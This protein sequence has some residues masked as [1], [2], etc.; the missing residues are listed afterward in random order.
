[1]NSIQSD[2][3]DKYTVAFYAPHQTSNTDLHIPY[4]EMTDNQKNKNVIIF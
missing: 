4:T 3:A 1:M 2:V